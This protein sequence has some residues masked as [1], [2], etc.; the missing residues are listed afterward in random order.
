MSHLKALDNV[1]VNIF[2]LV[3][4]ARA[5]R[6]VAPSKKFATESQCAAYTRINGMIFS[7]K[8]AK[9]NPLLRTFLVH[10]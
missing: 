1:Y 2:D 6:K 8:A 5:G 7:K 3:D 10:V 9:E 4:A